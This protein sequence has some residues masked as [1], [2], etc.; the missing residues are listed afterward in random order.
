MEIYIVAK[1]EKKEFVREVYQKLETLGHHIS[2]DWTTHKPIKPY[3][4]NQDIARIYGEN[5]ISAI[6]KSDVI[7]AFPDESGST[8]FLEIGAAMILA[9]KEGKPKVYVVGESNAKSPWFFSRYV[10]RCSS[11]DEVLVNMSS[12]LP[13]PL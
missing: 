2:Y 7:I 13:K 11:L 5:E 4:E 9:A 12:A 6:L 8:L 3:H 1:F 10:K